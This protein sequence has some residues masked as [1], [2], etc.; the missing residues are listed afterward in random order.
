MESNIYDK[1]FGNILLV[2][3]LCVF[4]SFEE[5]QKEVDWITYADDKRIDFI[6]GSITGT[7]YDKH[8]ELE[9]QDNYDVWNDDEEI[10]ATGL[11]VAQIICRR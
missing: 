4:L 6:Y 3:L 5:I 7:I 9:L 10:V 11:S 2:K 8:G 1:A